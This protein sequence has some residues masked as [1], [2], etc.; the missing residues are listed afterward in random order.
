MPDSAHFIL[1]VGDDDFLVDREARSRF[2]SLS[3]NAEDEMSREII[4]GTAT[5]VAEVESVMSAFLSATRT[6]SLFGGKK[7]VWL[8]NLNWL[9]DGVIRVKSADSGDV[10]A[11]KGK[12]RSAPKKKDILEDSVDK[13]AEEF[14]ASDPASLCV[15]ISV[16]RPDKRRTPCKK[17]LKIGELVSVASMS[18][19]EELIFTLEKAARELGSEIDEDAA[20]LLVGK[21]NGH[22]RMTFS[23]LEKLACYAG[24]GGRIDAETVMKLV[25]VFGAGDFFEPVEFFFNGDLAGTLAA[26]RRFFFNNT[27][28]RPLLSALQ[29]RNRLLIQLRALVDAGDANLSFRG[30]ISKSAIEAAGTRYGGLFG[31]NDEKSSLNL[32]SQNAWYV[33]E[34]VAGTTLKNKS[35]TLKRLIDWQLDFVRAFEELISRPGEDEA[36]MRELAARCLGK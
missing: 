18:D 9:A 14:A 15:V 10:P 17:L 22:M 16:V 19:S 30:G 32:F 8:R 13:I 33:G 11:K 26:L 28:A 31:G 12:G 3:A 25:P 34:K 29:N 24:R 7:Y 6:V 1:I 21:V 27:S 36:V 4:D 5:K 23:E 2:E 35:I 20:R